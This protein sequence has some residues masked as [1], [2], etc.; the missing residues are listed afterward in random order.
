MRLL[1]N[2]VGNRNRWLGLRL[3]GREVRRDMLGARVAVFT[4]ERTL[5]RRVR[6]DG[7]YGSAHDPRVLVG[8]GDA[9]KVNEVQV[10]WPSGLREE[11]NDVEPDRWSELREGTGRPVG[12]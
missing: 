11:W 3:V 6:S 5:W 8:L 1:R 7:S 2:N 12:S 4:D 10:L 9:G